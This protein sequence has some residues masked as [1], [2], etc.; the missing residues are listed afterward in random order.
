M[1]GEQGFEQSERGGAG[2]LLGGKAAGRRGGA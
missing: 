2:A 1:Y